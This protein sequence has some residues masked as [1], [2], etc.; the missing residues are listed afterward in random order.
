M[1]TPGS[2]LCG[3]T[4]SSYELATDNKTCQG[5]IMGGDYTVC[6]K[7]KLDSEVCVDLLY[8]SRRYIER[9]T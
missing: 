1:N 2:Y 9:H 5:K 6:L 8:K 7:N 4:N 3:C